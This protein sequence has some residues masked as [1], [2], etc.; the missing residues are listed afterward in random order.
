MGHHRPDTRI[1]N[2]QQ[3]RLD[4]LHIIQY[5]L[6]H[7]SFENLMNAFRRFPLLPQWET[8]EDIPLNCE[9]NGDSPLRVPK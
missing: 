9:T 3:H 5:G 1:R 8:D 2:Q 7:R 4:Y 6:A